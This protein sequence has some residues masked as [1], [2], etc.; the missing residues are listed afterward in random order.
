[1]DT[2][3]AILLG[4]GLGV[5]LAGIELVS[6]WGWWGGLGAIALGL[7]PVAAAIALGG[8][9]A[10]VLASG[11]AMMAVGAGRRGPPMLV[12]GLKHVLPGAALGFGLVRR[13]PVAV[14]TLLTA[15]ANLLGLVILLWVLSPAGVGPI[16]Y[17]ERQIAAHVN[18][19]EQWPAQFATAGQDPGWAA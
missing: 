18:E 15:I 14:T 8:H 4:T 6:S 17:L 5:G 16:T 11:I 3:R 12:V 7:V 10:A 1:P 13:L 2:R 9:V 19:L